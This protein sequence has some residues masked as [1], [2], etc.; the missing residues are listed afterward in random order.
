[1]QTLPE[2][3]PEQQVVPFVHALPRVVQP[4][5]PGTGWQVEPVQLP[6]QHSVPE[7]QAWVFCL[8][9][10]APH[11]LPVQVRLQ[12]SVGCVHDWPVVW[13]MPPA[14][15]WVVVSHNAVQQ[16]ALEMHESPT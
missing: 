4:P 8:H 1:M 15:L 10:A 2:Q 3:L 6:E 16:P 14:H 12:Q 9:A 13:H 5:P 11:E 7:P